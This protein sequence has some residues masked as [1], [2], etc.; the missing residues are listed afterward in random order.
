M[1]YMN[2]L[3]K[4]LPSQLNAGVQNPALYNSTKV[5]G[6]KSKS[7]KRSQKIIIQ[8]KGGLKN[9]LKNALKK[10]RMNKCNKTKKRKSSKKFRK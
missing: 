7:Q 9:A 6:R 8:K 2:G 4:V 10:S 3:D 1:N 5:G